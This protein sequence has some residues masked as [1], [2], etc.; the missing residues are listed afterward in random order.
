MG[1]MPGAF[2]YLQSRSAQLQELQAQR[3]AY[4]FYARMEAER[5][6]KPQVDGGELKA[7]EVP[8]QEPLA[9]PAPEKQKKA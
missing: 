6:Q 7:E 3:E 2:G 9:L 5:K 1:V 8:Q 4:E